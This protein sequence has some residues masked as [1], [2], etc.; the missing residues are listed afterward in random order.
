MNRSPRIT[1]LFYSLT[2]LFWLAKPAFAQ[3]PN[4]TPVGARP[5]SMGEAFVAVAD[6]GHAIHW[7]PAGLANLE[8]IQLNFSQADLFGLGIINQYASFLSRFYFIPPL[9]DYLSFGVA[10]SGIHTKDEGDGQEIGYGQ[11]Q[12]Y[13][14]LAFK[15]PKNSLAL[16]HLSIGANVKYLQLG[17]KYDGITA[18]EAKGRGVDFGLLYDFGALLS[19][20]KRNKATPDT[21]TTDTLATERKNNHSQQKA[22]KGDRALKSQ[23]PFYSVLRVLASVPQNLQIGL[24]MHDLGDTKVRHRTGVR[25]P[26]Q[27]QKTRLGFSYRAP[28]EWFNGKFFSD[29][30]LALDFDDRTHLGLEF[31]LMRHLAVRAGW[32]WSRH[33]DEND[34]FSFGMGLKLSVWGGTEM[35]GDF[36]RTDSPFLPAETQP[37]GMS[38]ILKNNPRLIRI[39]DTHGNDVFASFYPYYQRRD[40]QLGVIKIKN[41]HDDSMKVH[42]SFLDSEFSQLKTSLDTTLFVKADSTYTHEIRAIFK[43]TILQL[44]EPRLSGEVKVTYEYNNKPYNI[45]ALVHFPF[46]PK[47]S[48]TWEDPAKAS[49]FITPTDTLVEKLCE[50]ILNSLPRNRSP[51]SDKIYH[52][53]ALFEGLSSYG[54]KFKDDPTSPFTKVLK[55]PQYIDQIKYPGEFLGMNAENRQGDCDDLSVLYASLLESNKIQ[56]A[57]ID[58]PRHVFIMFDTEVPVNQIYRLQVDKNMLVARNGTL[59]VPIETTCIDSLPFT[60]AWRRG[61]EQYHAA[62]RNSFIKIFSFEE[63]RFKYEPTPPPK[64]EQT[65]DT[66]KVSEFHNNISRNFTMIKRWNDNFEESFMT[67]IKQDS[68][69]WQANN[70]LGIL[71]AQTGKKELAEMRLRWVCERNPRYSPALNNLA[72][73]YLM[74]ANTTNA[75]SGFYKKVDNLYARALEY[76]ISAK[77]SAGIYLNRARLYHSR[78]ELVP[79]DSSQMNYF[80]LQAGQ[81][82]QKDAGRA[83]E[84]LGMPVEPLEEEDSEKGRVDFKGLVKSFKKSFF[85]V[86]ELKGMDKER[87]QKQGRTR[88]EKFDALENGG[89]ILWWSI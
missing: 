4:Q 57:L 33:Q 22:T 69:N 23:N 77:D 43:R 42:F 87:S 83:F 41:L 60:E 14:A 10:W 49:A 50:K 15:P 46:H 74:Y 17:G 32:Q 80:L 38:L 35:S 37:F 36:A 88:S 55:K 29:P 34:V 18:G 58:I 72:N 66:L 45:S 70:E 76:A 86:F 65:L 84:I 82:L 27:F 48:I 75:D 89:M 79:Q 28:A 11:D 71:Y 21:A 9:A 40:S 64:G 25:E 16:R 47:N 44:Q 81:I 54:F 63:G 62:A 85:V 30:V 78:Q 6:D 52:A 56:T 13:L 61:I 24:M 20:Q 7:N 53:L 3:I 67:A 39:E 19:G 51:Y 1:L 8:R 31:L 73:L 59:W 26:V 2:A 5:L 12:A 68:A